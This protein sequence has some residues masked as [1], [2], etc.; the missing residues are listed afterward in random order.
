MPLDGGSLDPETGVLV[1]PWHGFRF[2]CASGECLTVPE[3]QLEG[4]PLRVES[5]RIVVRVAQ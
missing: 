3:A 1:C 5:G 2:D 4:L